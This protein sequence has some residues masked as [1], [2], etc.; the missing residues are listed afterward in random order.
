[1]GVWA[2][3]GGAT[4]GQVPFERDQ[5]QTAQGP[6]EITFIGHGTLM[7]SWNDR[8]IHIDPVGQYADYSKLPKAD[9]I[10][11]THEHGDHLDPKAIEQILKPTTSIVLNPNSAA[12]LGK[13]KAIKNGE[14]IEIR[15]IR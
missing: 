15:S 10:L 6:P 12:K 8:V 13:G 7:F 2:F 11:I 4:F 14:T 9:L 1:M 3:S 5:F